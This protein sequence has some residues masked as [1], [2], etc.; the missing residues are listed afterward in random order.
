M[1]NEILLAVLIVS[2]VGLVIGIVLA[3]ASVVMAVPTNEKVDAV[4]NELPGANCGA[5]GYSGCRAYAKAIV[6]GNATPDLC[7]V[8]GTQVAQKIGELMGVEVGEVVQK[9]AVAHCLGSCDNTERRF[10]YQGAHDCKSAT[11]LV[12]NLSSCI[13]GCMGLG[14]C[15]KACP[16]GAVEVCNG[17]ARVLVENCRG[18][19]M[20]AAACPKGLITLVPQKE[21]A[22][23]RCKNQHKGAIT[24]KD[25]NVGC[26]GCMKCVKVCG[27]GAIKVENFVATVNPDKC[28]GCAKCVVACPRG[29]I[30]PFTVQVAKL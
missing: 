9:V 14:D 30:T 11:N 10:N 1:P 26:I 16:Y 29:C 27:E 13:Y 8:G 22:V 15:V 5:C 2:G 21:Q 20:C 18:C 12:G 28:V 3:V 7:P 23:V 19:G 25:C 6:A 4:R 24:R 17:V